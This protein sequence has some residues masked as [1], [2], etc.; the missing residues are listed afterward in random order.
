[1]RKLIF[2]LLCPILFSACIGQKARKHPERYLNSE[3]FPADLKK[4]GYVLLI[5]K[6]E[7]SPL[8]AKIQNRRVDDLMKKYYTKPYE[9]VSSSDL[10]SNPKYANKNVYR[11][12][13]RQQPLNAVIR[14]ERN[15]N[16]VE[17]NSMT[18]V[19]RD[20]YIEDRVTGKGFPGTGLRG[21]S[22]QSD[23]MIVAP[24]LA[25]MK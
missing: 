13:I 1:M 7:S 2:I 21:D 12:L 25:K 24:Y 5:L 22:Y 6:E 9:M 8:V 20:I 14:S 15:Q 3:A 11:Y 23:M 18:F 17:I 4:D 10:S 16:N 19:H